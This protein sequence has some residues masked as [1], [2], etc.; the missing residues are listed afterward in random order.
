VAGGFASALAR[1]RCGE[2]YNESRALILSHPV[3]GA[4]RNRNH[5]KRLGY[6]LERLLAVNRSISRGIKTTESEFDGLLDAAQDAIQNIV[7]KPRLNE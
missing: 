5:P 4:S 1:H 7:V 6:T 3:S 2:A